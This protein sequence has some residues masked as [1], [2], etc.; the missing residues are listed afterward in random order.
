MADDVV[1]IHLAAPRPIRFEIG[2][3]AVTISGAI[4]MRRGLETRQLLTEL[5]EAAVQ[6]DVKVAA[7]GD[8][9]VGLRDGSV[10]IEKAI[11]I[12]KEAEDAVVAYEEKGDEIIEHIRSLIASYDPKQKIPDLDMN[13]AQ[14]IAATVWR[15]AMGA[16]DSQLETPAPGDADPPTQNRSQRRS[17][18]RAGS[19][20]SVKPTVD[21]VGAVRRHVVGR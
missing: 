18:S 9:A 2:P 20:S 14:Q 19:T 5:D 3:D 10:E 7:A 11:E 16:T 12:G 4:S 6:M 21:A 15:R 1:N 17:T 8:L 13:A